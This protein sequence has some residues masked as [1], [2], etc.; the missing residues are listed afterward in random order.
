MVH[1]PPERQG[2]LARPGPDPSGMPTRVPI[3]CLEGVGQPFEPQEAR[4]LQTSVEVADLARVEE[5]PLVRRLE[6]PVLGGEICEALYLGGQP[7]RPG[8]TGSNR[9]GSWIVREVVRH[10]LTR[11]RPR[12]PSLRPR[13]HA[14]TPSHRGERTSSSSAA[15]TR[16]RSIAT[17]YGN[18][19][20][21][22]QHRFH[23]KIPRGP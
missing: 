20:A 3:P 11:S 16:R 14:A 23:G 4:A 22:R 2:R 18:L 8:K 9:V 17:A 7:S 13:R 15:T 6:T 1:A 10:W 5:R 21:S 12:A 19:R